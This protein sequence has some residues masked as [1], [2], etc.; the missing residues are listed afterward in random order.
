MG[1]SN[2]YK[3]LP[4]GYWYA[5][6]LQEVFDADRENKIWDEVPVAINYH[7]EAEHTIYMD[8][9]MPVINSKY[10]FI[11]G[12]ETLRIYMCL[13]L[14]ECHIVALSKEQHDVAINI[15]NKNLI[16]I[17]HKEANERPCCD[18]R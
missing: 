3:T 6:K 16:D 7:I 9:D 14:N 18:C 5:K 11:K 15:A 8:Y 10:K 17:V 2:N 13:D 1:N 12:V 4:C